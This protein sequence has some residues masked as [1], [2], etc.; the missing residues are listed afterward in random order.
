MARTVVL[1]VTSIPGVFSEIAGRE[2][3]PNQADGQTGELGLG[4][5]V[6]FL[7]M[8]GENAPGHARFC[9]LLSGSPS[10]EGST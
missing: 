8:A 9:K 4:V 10:R 3:R 7:Q 1:D 2:Y 5:C 6:R